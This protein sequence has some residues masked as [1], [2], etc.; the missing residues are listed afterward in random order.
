MMDETH[1]IASITISHCFKWPFIEKGGN[2]RFL[3]THSFLPTKSKKI[4]FFLAII[5]RKNDQSIFLCNSDPS[6]ANTEV[7]RLKQVH[8]IKFIAYFF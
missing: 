6:N 7:L 5:A 3:K 4:G 1:K 8:Y 2:F